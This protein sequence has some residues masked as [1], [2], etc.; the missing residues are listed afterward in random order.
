M[1]NPGDRAEIVTAALR[2]HGRILLCH[3]SAQRLHYPNLWAFPGGNVEAGETAEQALVRELAEELGIKV[4]PPSNRP[5]AV[6]ETNA[7]HMQIW[8]IESWTGTTIRLPRTTVLP[9]W[10]QSVSWELIAGSW[11][12]RA[13]IWAG[14]KTDVSGGNLKTSTCP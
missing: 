7:F 6:I 10:F 14:P 12:M 11:S 1:D 3:R 4:T 8:L 9:D 5:T 13:S 2:Q